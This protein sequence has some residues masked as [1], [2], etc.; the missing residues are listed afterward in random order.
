M[1]NAVLNTVMVGTTVVQRCH[2]GSFVRFHA[3]NAAAC[4]DVPGIYRGILQDVSP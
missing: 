2:M 3:D 1:L 4:Y